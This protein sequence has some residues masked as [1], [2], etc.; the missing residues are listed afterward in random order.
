MSYSILRR[1]RPDPLC[2]DQQPFQG[3]K[4]PEEALEKVAEM[5]KEDQEK[6]IK[7]DYSVVG[8]AD[9]AITGPSETI[10]AFS[11]EWR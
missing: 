9:E 4:T 7:S 10:L 3:F 2:I 5:R 6:G 1:T 8:R 11:G